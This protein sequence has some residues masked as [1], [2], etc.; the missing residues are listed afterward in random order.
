MKKK[1]IALFLALAMLLSLTAC[2]KNTPP[3]EEKKLAMKE[4]ESAITTVAENNSE[5]SDDEKS[6]TD[7]ESVTQQQNTAEKAEDYYLTYVLGKM[8]V[9]GKETVFLTDQRDMD[10][11]QVLIKDAVPGEGEEYARIKFIGI[12]WKADGTVE[13]VNM[14]DFL[15]MNT[16]GSLVSPGTGGKLSVN[17]YGPD[18]GTGAPDHS[19]WD[20]AVNG[21]EVILTSDEGTIYYFY[22]DHFDEQ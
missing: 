6:K 17:G 7:A 15:S 3:A 21:T 14:C 22:E 19:D 10:N 11:W 12:D 9:D 20:M 13:Q 16:F 4:A 5:L 1:I 2:T 8:V 18:P